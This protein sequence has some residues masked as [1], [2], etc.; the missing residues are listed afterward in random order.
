MVVRGGGAR[1]ALLGLAGMVL[2]GGG[3]LLAGAGAYEPFLWAWLFWGGLST[4]SVALLLVHQV[5][6]GRWGDALRP[7]LVAAA[8]ALPLV[9]L[10]VG[11]LL[12]GLAELYPWARGDVPHP[13]G[14]FS[15]MFF[16]GRALVYLVLLLGLAWVAGAFGLP[17]RR[18]RGQG[19]GGAAL[20]VLV[21]TTTLA[22]FDWVMSLDP[23]WYSAIFG[24]L[25]G[26]AQVVAGL[27]LATRWLA[28]AEG[29]LPDRPAT[30]QLHDA[31]N[32]LLAGV[33][34][35]A[36]LGFMQFL[37]IW[38]ANLPEEIRWY[39]PRLQTDWRWLGLAVVGLH[40][41]APL[42]LLLSR[43]ARRSPRILGLVAGVV[44]LG[45]ALYALWLTLPTLRPQAARLEAADALL[46][47]GVGGLWLGL[48]MWR[49]PGAATA[50]GTSR[51]EVADGG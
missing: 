45:Q 28:T 51:Q 33:L 5:T 25:V 38:S 12:F 3:A 22:A 34:L 20:L 43:R 49:L 24:L 18:L 6:G 27:A 50:A 9:A 42:V 29:R 10:L 21:L 35:W 41:L 48:F 46:F 32:L 36:Y 23:H 2:A 44:L 16:S 39:V 17:A 31:A 4:G 40:L 47:L 1:G 11:P 13:S 14:L 15:P 8:A 26:V 37:T 19:M 30:R 7:P